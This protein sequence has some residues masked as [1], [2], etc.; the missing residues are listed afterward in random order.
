MKKAKK[1]VKRVAL[2]KKDAK[3]VKS[4]YKEGDYALLADAIMHPEKF[5]KAAAEAGRKSGVTKE[6]QKLRKKVEQAK[7]RY[8][9][10][11][12][13]DESKPKIL[14][15]VR[16]VYHDGQYLPALCFR[17]P[18]ALH[19]P[20][21]AGDPVTGVY[22]FTINAMQHDKST[23]LQRGYGNFATEYPP[24]V[25]ADHM[26]RIAA[27]APITPE[28]RT[29]LLPYAPDMPSGPGPATVPAP[30]DGSQPVARAI[31]S[32]TG[33]RA[34][35]SGPGRTSGKDL[36]RA[37]AE[38]TKLPPEKVRAKLRASGMRAPY[39][40]EDECRKALGLK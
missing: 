13:K 34:G 16:N 38:Q 17:S 30:G 18:G 31:A 5:E 33:S 21:V 25:F 26:R 7:A 6:S 10:R 35:V 4:R 27:T 37:L 28:A 15:S 12:P 3:P 32:R 1:K 29:L 20:C 8:P 24:Q 22:K 40:N 36:I 9:E 39:V 11:V 14:I 2:S 23:I 19:I